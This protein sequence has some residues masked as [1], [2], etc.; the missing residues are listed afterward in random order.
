MNPT[1]IDFILVFIFQISLATNGFSELAEQEMPR[2]K[3]TA[4]GA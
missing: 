4:A 3:L 2:D 1:R